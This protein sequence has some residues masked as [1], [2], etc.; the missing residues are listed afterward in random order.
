MLLDSSGKLGISTL[1]PDALLDIGSNNII[2][3]DDTGSSTG[4]IGMGSFNNGTIN[5]AQGASYY[6]FGIEI[7]RPNANISF[8]AYA[9]TGMT[10]TGTNILNLHR[11][12][13]VGIGKEGQTTLNVSGKNLTNNVAQWIGDGWVGNDSY[14]IEGGLLG[15]SGT[16][17]GVQTSA[18]IAFQTRT[19][20]D[21]NYWKSSILM[22]RDGRMEFYTG[23]AGTGS[24]NLRM[25]V[26]SSGSVVIGNNPDA[27]AGCL[28]TLRTSA[29]T[30]LSIK[31]GSNTG[32][33]FINF[34]DGDDTNPGQIY[35]GHS[36]DKMVFRTNDGPRMTIESDGSIKL[37]GANSNRTVVC[38]NTADGSDSKYLALAGG[39][40]DTDG[41]GA[42]MRLFGNEHAT[43]AGQVDLSTGNIAGADMHLRAKDV[44][45]FYTGGTEHLQI[46]NADYG[47]IKV[48]A[49]AG[50]NASAAILRLE[51][52]NSSAFG[53]SIIADSTIESVTDGNAYGANLIFKVNDTSNVLQERIRIDSSATTKISSDGSNAAGTILE[54]LFPNNNT[55]DVCSTIN[56]TNNVGGYAAIET[57]TDGANNSG[58]I[59]FKTDNAGTQGERLRI[60]PSGAI[61]ANERIKVSGS[62]TDQYF[63]EG[64]RNGVGVTYRLYDNSNNVYHDSYTSQVFRVNQIGGS[65]GKFVVQGGESE[66]IRSTADS[67]ILDLQNT[68]INVGGASADKYSAIRFTNTTSGGSHCEIRQYGNAWANSNSDLAFFT[69]ETAGTSEEKLRILGSGESRFGWNSGTYTNAQTIAQFG[70][71]VVPNEYGISLTS[72]G[73]ALSGYFGSNVHFDNGSFS[74]PNSNRSSGYMEIANTTAN[75][76]GSTFRFQ[77]ATKGS[78]SIVTRFEINEDSQMIY[79]DQK[80]RLFAVASIDTT[81]YTVATITGAGNGSSANIEFVGQGGTS[82]I[83]DVVYSCTNQ[84]GNWYAYKKERQ[85]PSLVDVDVSGHGTTTLTFTFKSLSGTQ[86]YTPRLRM[87][88]S[89]VNLVTF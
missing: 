28:L 17:D 82:G 2:T 88:G 53:G 81:G 26:T 59:A 37:E 31:S 83:V 4:F 62:A 12:G 33:S 24:D 3:L 22:N 32:E 5:R 68:L 49:K 45:Y 67:T 7:D 47:Q 55:S 18:G 16:N 14:H 40:A 13:K 29:S 6:G 46:T 89:P 72:T 1:T 20:A 48:K 65:G 77:T 42:R 60:Q 61:D 15:I 43:N 57:G 21:N 38:M 25:N 63:F 66:F 50:T 41:Q 87:L 36:Q 80:E 76:K 71:T 8:N 10:T 23:G 30:G 58:Y 9:S 35:Y 54:L 44:M 56:F 69:S 70:N 34:G 64:Q 19:T 78:T 73:D 11:T 86:G 39:G 84:G 75:G 85:T 27:T 51:G 79:G 74:K 52:T